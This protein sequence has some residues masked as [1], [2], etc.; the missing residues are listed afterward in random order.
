M[1]SCLL[2]ATIGACCWV[3]AYARLLRLWFGLLCF[4]VYCFTALGV[5]WWR[6][7]WLFVLLGLGC[8]VLV[9]LVD[10]LL[11]DACVRVLYVCVRWFSW[12]CFDGYGLLLDL[13]NVVLRLCCVTGLFDC[14]HPAGLG[15]GS[16]YLV[17]LV[18]VVDCHL[19][20]W[21]RCGCVDYLLG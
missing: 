7:G 17:L 1:D 12:V 8:G 13:L 6:G 4:G 5:V 16:V 21:L 15:V 9:Y 18:C 11:V 10:R 19:A 20:L 2:I 14:L 3:L